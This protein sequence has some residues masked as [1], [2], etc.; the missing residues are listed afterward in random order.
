MLLSL[1]MIMLIIG[2]SWDLNALP[3][4]FLQWQEI[5]FSDLF[6]MEIIKYVIWNIENGTKDV[7]VVG[8]VCIVITIQKHML[9]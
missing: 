6:G 7:G 9:G 3:E 8:I 5:S 1:V 4:A 2:S